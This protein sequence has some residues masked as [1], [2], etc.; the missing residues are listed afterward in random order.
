MGPGVRRDDE[1]YGANFNRRTVIAISAHSGNA[2]A[3]IP[4]LLSDGPHRPIAGRRSMTRFKLFYSAAILS[5]LSATP[6]MAQHMI[7]EPGM[8]AFVHPNG[9][10][11]I[12]STRSPADARAM[13]LFDDRNKMARQGMR[14]KSP[15]IVAKR[16]QSS[17]E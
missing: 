11:G 9:D 6:A 2:E 14:T 5:A 7:D 10:L 4:V 15:S 17:N 8:F 12:A 1:G 13:M 16:T 3:Q